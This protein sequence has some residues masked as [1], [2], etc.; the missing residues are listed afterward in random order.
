MLYRFN[1][2]AAAELIMMPDGAKQMFT[3]LGRDLAPQ[4]II[5][6][7]DL[8]GAIASLNGAIEADEEH[9]KQSQQEAQLRGEEPARRVGVRFRQRAWPLL[10]MLRQS[11]AMGV[12]VIWTT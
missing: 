1:S 8:S 11:H 10:E 9:W 5:E 2:K 6:R 12:D 7:D 4:G 3:A